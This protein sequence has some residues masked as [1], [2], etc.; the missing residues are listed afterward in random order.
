MKKCKCGNPVRGIPQKHKQ[1]IRVKKVGG[2]SN[3]TY[4]F[5]SKPAK[6]KLCTTCFHFN[7][8]GGK[9]GPKYYTNNRNF[10]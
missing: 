5:P 10:S 2:T 1:S 4:V 7:E 3:Y 6:D 8:A 9:F